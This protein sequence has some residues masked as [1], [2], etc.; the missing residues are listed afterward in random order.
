MLN[1]EKSPLQ[2]NP[3]CQSCHS[4]DMEPR[5]HVIDISVLF[6]CLNSL[7]KSYVHAGKKL[8]SYKREFLLYHSIR[9]DCQ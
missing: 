5:V 4:L 9:K 6:C 3:C 1:T 2:P 7:K 8:Q